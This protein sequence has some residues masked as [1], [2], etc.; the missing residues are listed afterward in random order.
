[1]IKMTEVSLYIRGQSQKQAT[2]CQFI[3]ETKAKMWSAKVQ[4]GN[5]MTRVTTELNTKMN[6]KKI[7]KMIVQSGYSQNCN[8]NIAF[9]APF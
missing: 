2:A 4:F 3:L 7:T 5:R 8:K 9:S 1:M 6:T